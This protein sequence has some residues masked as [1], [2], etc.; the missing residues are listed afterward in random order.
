MSSG[1]KLR[2]GGSRKAPRSRARDLIGPALGLSSG[3]HPGEHRLNYKQIHAIEQ[4]YQTHPAIQAA[5]TILHGQLLS[6]GIVLRRDG[7]VVDLKPAFKQ[8]LDELW[9]PF[10]QQV[11][12][13]FLKF[14]YC[15]VSY[16][17]D[18]DSLAYQSAKRRKAGGKTVAATAPV[19]LIPIVPPTDTYEIAYIMAGRAGYHRRYLVYGLAPHMAAKV[20]DEARVVV[21]Q[22]PDPEGNV[23]SPMATIFDLGSFVSA[24][25]ELAM[26]AEITNARPR[27][28]TQVTACLSRALQNAIDQ[29]LCLAGTKANQ[30]GRPGSAGPF[31]RQRV[32]RRC[33]V[34]RRPGQRRSRGRVGHAGPAHESDQPAADAPAA[35]GPERL[36]HQHRQLLRR[37]G[38]G[39]ALNGSTGGSAKSYV[40]S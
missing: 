15:T 8:H 17:E 21:R 24:L 14:G 26:T 4:L 27:V 6:G 23:N 29:F 34:G 11:I 3:E 25:T 35:C 19:N 30:Q 39:Q 18:L 1:V 12:D 7:E 36:R 38:D 2:S 5:R 13:S 16:E 40:H 20:D 33:R 9:I 10:A 22:H 32:A 37:R 31:L 28:W